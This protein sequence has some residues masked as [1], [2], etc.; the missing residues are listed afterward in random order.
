VGCLVAAAFLLRVDGIARPS[1]STRELHNALLAR[2]YYLGDGAG[3]PMWKQRVLRELDRSVKPVE[4]PLL[5]H[6]AAWGYRIAGREDLWIPRLVSAAF[7]VLGGLFV[8]LIGLRITRREGALVA[9]ALYL[10]WP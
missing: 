5:D 4:P 9:A 7:W 6:V 3:L 10:F 1:L 2:E 8:Y